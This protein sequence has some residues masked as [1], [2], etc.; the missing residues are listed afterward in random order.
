M[1]SSTRKT[2]YDGGSGAVYHPLHIGRQVKIY[3]IQEHELRT[4]GVFN[5]MMVLWCSVG[6][7]AIALLLS[8]IW[9]MLLSADPAGAPAVLFAVACAI[10]AVISF[11]LAMYFRKNKSDFLEQILKETED[12]ANG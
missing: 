8:C 9:D 3:P 6:S 12:G 10:V 2:T 7:S 1:S 11:C 5:S 4:I